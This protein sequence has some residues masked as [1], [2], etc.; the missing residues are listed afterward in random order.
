[1]FL[2]ILLSIIWGASFMLIKKSLISFSPV[3]L[4]MLRVSI[5]G[6]AFLPLALMY[7]KRIKKQDW[8]I[9]II[10]GL[11][12]NAL[13]AFLYALAQTKVDSSVAGILNGMTPIFTLLISVLVFKRPFY[14]KQMVGILLGFIGVSLLILS[15]DKHHSSTIHII[16]PILVIIATLCYGISGNVVENQLKGKAPL[17]IASM[18]VV[19]VMIPCLIILFS[20]GFV[21]T[22]QSEPLA[23]QSFGYVSFLAIINTV[24]AS[25]F[26]YKLVQISGA[27]FSSSVTYLIPIVAVGL[28]FLDGEIIMLVH[29]VSIIM[30]VAG[31]YYAKNVKS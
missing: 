30:I 16:F 1:M 24:I 12:G 2:M 28:G 11:T 5:S 17:L 6:I 29:F 22:M 20:M 31:V 25:I 23:W 10:V 13:P 14:W 19:S 15:G 8:V 3:Q 7:L 18:S 27:V 21:E 4:S 26:F 9:F